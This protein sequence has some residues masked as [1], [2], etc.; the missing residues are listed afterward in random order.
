[1]RCWSN[2]LARATATYALT[3]LGTAAAASLIDAARVSSDDDRDK[4][5]KER[6]LENLWENFRDGVILLNNIPLVND[7]LSIAQGYTNLE[8][9]TDFLVN[10]MSNEQWPPEQVRAYLRVKLPQLKHWKQPQP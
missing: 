1:M 5:Y 7:I 10:H 6:Y 8:Q 3:A 9:L 2:E 4:D